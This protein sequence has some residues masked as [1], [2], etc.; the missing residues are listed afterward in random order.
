MDDDSAASHGTHSRYNMGCRCPDCTAANKLH[1][2]DV[3]ARRRGLPVTPRS[4][5]VKAWEPPTEPGEVE[6][7]VAE[8]LAT[9]S[10]A[11]TRPGIVA[12]CL[13]MARILD[14]PDQFPTHVRAVT[15]LESALKSLR[16]ASGLGVRGRGRLASVQPIN[17]RKKR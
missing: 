2:R 15:S 17:G 6:L 11:E 13:Q 12:G 8:E 7:A 10:A 16:K 5:A 3:R 14:S 4:G 1:V 9:L